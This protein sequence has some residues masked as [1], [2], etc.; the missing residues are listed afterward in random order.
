MKDLVV[1]V[2]DKNMEAAVRTLL[3]KR[4]PALGIRSLE[5]DIFVHPERD[6]GV[7]QR[8]DIFLKGFNQTHRYALVL[9]DYQ[10][11]GRENLSVDQ[12]RNDLKNRLEEGGWQGRCEVVVI[13]PEL[14]AWVWSNSPHV[15]K[16]LGVAQEDMETILQQYR[17]A[18]ATKPSRPKEAMEACLR[19]AGIPRSSSLYRE[20]AEKVSLKGCVDR[21]FIQLRDT[22]RDWFPQ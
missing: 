3:E 12:L 14:E 18:G 20:L 16:V 8:A 17:D 15:P 21:A 5:A 19:K 9:F 7:L 6:P 4:A 11:C 2:A 13:D 1:L 22:L 10:G